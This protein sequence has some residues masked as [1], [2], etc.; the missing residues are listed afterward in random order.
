M[1]GVRD[2]PPDR[3]TA[4]MVGID[5][6]G[7]VTTGMYTDPLAIYREYIQNAAD[8]F[9]TSASLK[10]GRVDISIDTSER[11]IV[12]RDDGPGLTLSEAERAL[13]PIGASQK[14][15]G[16]CRGFRGIG[17]LVGLAFGD[18]VTFS[19]RSGPREPVVRVVWN[20]V[21]LRHGIETGGGLEDTL[22]KATTVGTVDGGDAYPERFFEVRVDGISRHSASSV[23]NGT[24]VREYIAEICPVPFRDDFPFA[25][26]FSNLFGRDNL[27]TLNVFVNGEGP[28]RRPHQGRMNLSESKN[29]AII[30]FEEVRIPGLKSQEWCALG[31]IGHTLYRGAL[32]KDLGVR[33]IRARMGNVQIGDEGV[34]DHLFSEDRFNRWCIAEIHILGDGIVPNVRRDYF[35]SN[36]HLRNLENQLGAVCRRLERR[37]RVASRGRL[38]RRRCHN[39]VDQTEGFLEIASAGY[40]SSDAVEKL[41]ADGVLRTSIWRKKYEDANDDGIVDKLNALDDKLNGFQLNFRKELVLAGTDKAEMAAYQKI[42]GIIFEIAPDPVAAKRTIEKILERVSDRRSR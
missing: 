40:L 24:I 33:G 34:F 41:V 13:V 36:P 39:F 1:D 42:F 25:A 29:E 18:S 9:D 8:S 38:E 22:G 3:S 35:E 37:C 27:L 19:T 20:G 4:E 6:L 5:V 10:T 11:R 28:I 16:R 17:R 23:M 32:A 26:V 7:L 31:W 30:E 12:I 21:R 15:P 2:M 14:R